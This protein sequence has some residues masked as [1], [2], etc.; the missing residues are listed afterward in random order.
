M[1]TFINGKKSSCYSLKLSNSTKTKPLSIINKN[2][3]QQGL[4]P[5]DW[6][7]GN[8]ISVHKKTLNK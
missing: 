6:E 8:I 7:K 2:C 1:K 3:L 5:N 4:F